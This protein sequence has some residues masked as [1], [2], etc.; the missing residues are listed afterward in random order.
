MMN[1]P[2]CRLEGTLDGKMASREK[3][4]APCQERKAV[5]QAEALHPQQEAKIA[6]G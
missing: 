5:M 6:F 3:L 1:D 2:A 4:Q